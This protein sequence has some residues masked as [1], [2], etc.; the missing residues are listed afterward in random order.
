MGQSMEDGVDARK[1][2]FRD[3]ASHAAWN[4]FEE[5][6]GHILGMGRQQYRPPLTTNQMRARIEERLMQG[7]LVNQTWTCVLNTLQAHDTAEREILLDDLSAVTFVRL[8]LWIL[9]PPPDGRQPTDVQQYRDK[10]R[11]IV[12][13]VL[14]K[15]AEEIT[16]RYQRCGPV[17]GQ[18]VVT[19][20]LRKWLQSALQDI[21]RQRPWETIPPERIQQMCRFRVFVSFLGVCWNVY[22]QW[23]G[24][25]LLLPHDRHKDCAL[26]WEP[27]RP[28]EKPSTN[29]VYD[30]RGS[31][32]LLGSKG[33][34]QWHPKQGCKEPLPQPIASADGR[35]GYTILL[36]LYIDPIT[37]W[38]TITEVQRCPV[39]FIGNDQCDVSLAIEYV[40]D[41]HKNNNEREQLVVTLTGCASDRLSS[42]TLPGIPV[43][44]YPDDVNHHLALMEV[45]IEHLT[46]NQNVHALS[47]RAKFF[48]PE[49]TKVIQNA[50]QEWL[51]RLSAS[52][53][54]FLG[55]RPPRLSAFHS[56]PQNYFHH[57]QSSAPPLNKQLQSAKR[58][59]P[60]PPWPADVGF[61][62]FHLECIP[63]LLSNLE[64]IVL[65][66]RFQGERP[67]QNA[68]SDITEESE[69]DSS[70][71][72]RSDW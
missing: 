43:F 25:T 66:R 58:L 8:W 29:S 1:E 11:D 17:H 35:L 13:D 16:R 54:L 31:A 62:F 56:S 36:H 39:L 69:G 53:E 49:V 23:S 65:S 3:D 72:D 6:P 41:P 42:V 24:D 57:R 44:R 60:S 51:S 59:R 48:G 64:V 9:M 4:C 5:N 7:L 12:A 52:N 26:I 61:W 33:I 10:E 63:L 14:K 28:G 21:Y 40:L 47:V 71:D 67:D 45:R 22:R 32:V 37:D 30:E 20:S 55:K 38:R 19:T 68:L 70:G 15:S 46:V 27:A 18:N 2:W 34:L 50:R